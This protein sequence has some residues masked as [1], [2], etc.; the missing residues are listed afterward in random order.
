MKYYYNPASS[1]C[2]KV[3]AVLHHTGLQVERNLVD[4]AKGEQRAPEF[5]AINPN[6]MVPSLVDGDVKLW[7][8]NAIMGYLCSRAESDL[9]PKTDVRYDILRW[10]YWELA[11]F[12]AAANTVLYE[13]LVKPNIG[14]GAPDEKIVDRGLTRFQRF[15]KVLDTHL[16]GRT[17]IIGDTL[18]IADF[19]VGA[20]LTNAEPGQL[21]LTP[22]PALVEWRSRL[23]DVPAWR[24]TAPRR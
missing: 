19:A 18:T 3:D 11:H 8:S 9:W 7:E 1:N 20:N 17:W 21:D 2:R 12:G 10:M 14:Q 13:R 24:A 5:L 16:K 4:L 23:D 15:A 22:Y 6:G